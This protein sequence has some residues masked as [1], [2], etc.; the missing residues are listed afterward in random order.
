V[1]GGLSAV[2]ASASGPSAWRSS[3]DADLSIEDWFEGKLPMLPPLHT[4]H[5]PRSPE[6]FGGSR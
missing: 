6:L 5:L 1:S 2:A 4:C 3:E